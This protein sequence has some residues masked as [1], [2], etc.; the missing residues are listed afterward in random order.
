MKGD[1][2]VVA[3][4]TANQVL[5]IIE[6]YVRKDKIGDLIEDTITLLRDQYKRENP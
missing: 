2:M 5:R 1:N 4:G 3:R 6:K